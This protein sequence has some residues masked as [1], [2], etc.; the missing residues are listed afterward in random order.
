MALSAWSTDA[1]ESLSKC[2][3]CDNCTRAPDALEKKDVTLD[4]WRVLKVVQTI[5]EE[6]GQVTVGMLA[7]LVRGAG[8]A[9]FSVAQQGGG[10]KRKSLSKEKVGL[11]LDA[12]AGGKV[13][14]GKDV[15][16]IAALLFPI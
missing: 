5:Q 3:H 15:C 4:A 11:D 8:G 7:D 12:I 9:A 14:L 2:G 16:F 13:S 6:G 10:R 1:S